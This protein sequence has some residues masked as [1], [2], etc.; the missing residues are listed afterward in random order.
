RPQPVEPNVGEMPFVDLITNGGAAVA[1]GRQRIELAGAPVRAVAVGEFR[2]FDDP[3]CR[4]HDFL[5]VFMLCSRIS[6]SGVQVDYRISS[7]RSRRANSISVK[8]ANNA[9][10]TAPSSTKGNLLA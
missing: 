2:A 1:V 7:H 8:I 6:P 10:R 5:P 4:C 9:T 3:F